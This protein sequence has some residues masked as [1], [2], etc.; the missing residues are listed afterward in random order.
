MKRFPQVKNLIIYKSTRAGKRFTA[1]F[2]LAG[3]YHRVHF[4]LAGAFTWFDGAP[5][6]KRDSYRARAS[7]IKNAQGRYTYKIAGTANSFA[8]YI[9]W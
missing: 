3:V 8:Y 1:E 5:A 7:K 2:D 6:T 4:G 9:L